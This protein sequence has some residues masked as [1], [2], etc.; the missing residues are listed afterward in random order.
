VDILYSK[1]MALA[2]S[3]GAAV[4]SPGLCVRAVLIAHYL[5]RIADHGVGIG[6]STV[7][8]V[9]GRRDGAVVRQ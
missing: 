2:S 9:T 3:N 8:M 4:G 5:E 6:R 7:F 1:I